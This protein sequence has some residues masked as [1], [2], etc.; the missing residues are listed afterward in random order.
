MKPG[1]PKPASR[2]TRQPL[3][4]WNSISIRTVD[5]PIDEQ[6]AV[7]EQGPVEEDEDPFAILASM[8]RGTQPTNL[9]DPIAE[10]AS[11]SEADTARSN[12]PIASESPTVRTT[13][14]TT[15]YQYQ[16]Q[17]YG[18]R[19][20]ANVPDIETTE[21]P[22]AAVALADDL[23]IPEVAFEDDMPFAPDFDDFEAELASA[24]GQQAVGTPVPPASEPYRSAVREVPRENYEHEF[25]TSVRPAAIGEQA[26]GAAMAT[27]AIASAPVATHPAASDDRTAYRH[28]EFSSRDRLPGAY[29][30]EDD[31]DLDYDP[32]LREEMAISSYQEAEHR[33]SSRRGLVI[34]VVVGGLAVIGGVG[35]FAFSSGGAS[36]AP[37]LVRADSD[38][39]KVRPVNPGGTTVPNQDNKVFQTMN[40]TDK[41][42][43]P[44]QE[45]LITGEEEPVDVAARAEPPAS[46]T[47]A[48]E[49]A[50][51]AA[52]DEA[53]LA[54][55]PV[56]AEIAAAPKGEERVAPAGAEEAGSNDQLVAIAPRRVRTMVVRADGTLVPSEEPVLSGTAP[57]SAAEARAGTDA[58]ALEPADPSQDLSDPAV[59]PEAT[60]SLKPADA[61]PTDFAP[62]M[63]SAELAPDASQPAAVA[64]TAAPASQEEAANMPATGPVAPSRPADQPVDVVGEVKPQKVAS[65][66]AAAAVAS[67]VGGWSV[68][69][70]SQPSEAAAKSSYDDLARRYASVI[71]DR[72]VNIVKADIAG[73]GTFWRVRLPAGSRNEAISLCESYKSAGGNC[74]VSK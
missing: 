36:D 14:R 56:A 40:G 28:Q 29:G 4:R 67:T 26:G 13:E 46:Q 65:A 74:F 64:V 21:V 42:A 71:G 61:V 73:K 58:A 15:E 59:T 48:S 17:S 47:E 7:S 10:P 22:E 23:E 44:T 12:A 57:A 6:A 33:P 70:A 66:E 5:D 60:A 53:A 68:Q 50:M 16:H 24:F 11:K 38:P 49:A 54:D 19:A 63:A 27:L 8:L 37:S 43:S 45:K 51:L 3:K 35:A 30:A 9:P 2:T 72:G 52:D 34:A 25:A 62:S 69:I 39:V 1:R 31:E 41:A 18:S 55:D 32:A 20:P